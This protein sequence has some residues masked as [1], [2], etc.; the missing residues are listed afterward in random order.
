MIEVLEKPFKLYNCL[1]AEYNQ[2]K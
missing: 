1:L 2:S